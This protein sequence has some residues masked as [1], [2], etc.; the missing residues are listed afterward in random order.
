MRL[1][2]SCT[3]GGDGRPLKADVVDNDYTAHLL[4][5]QIAGNKVK[6]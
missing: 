5:V 3:Y 2:F 4:S 6:I 1:D